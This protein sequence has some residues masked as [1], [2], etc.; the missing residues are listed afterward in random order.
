[1][2]ITKLGFLSLLSC[3]SLASSSSLIRCATPAELPDQ[4]AINKNIYGWKGPGVYRIA[5]F[6]NWL[7]LNVEI[8]TDGSVI[9][10]Q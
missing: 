1:M 9:N 3:V 8:K 7:E 5:T 4:V 2:Q 10:L 6:A